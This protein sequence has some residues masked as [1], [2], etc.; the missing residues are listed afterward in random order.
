M[1]PE[2]GRVRRKKGERKKRLKGPFSSL[3]TISLDFWGLFQRL[4][5]FKLNV[6]YSASTDLYHNGIVADL[7]SQLSQVGW[8]KLREDFNVINSFVHQLLIE[9]L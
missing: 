5:T 8:Q 3:S 4:V 1:L 2:A 7:L 6:S 9:H